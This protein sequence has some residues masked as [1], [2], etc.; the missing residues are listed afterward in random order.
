MSDKVDFGPRVGCDPEFFV[1]MKKG[2]GDEPPRKNTIIP[3]CGLFG[4]TK[5]NPNKLTFK[6]HPE[7]V[8][9]VR[10][11]I[12]ND[13]GDY[14]YQEDN[15]TFEFNIPAQ[16]SYDRFI[17]VVQGF[18]MYLQEQVLAPKRMAFASINSYNFKPP[19]LEHPFAQTIGCTPDHDA[20]AVGSPIRKA[21]DIKGLGT[22]R[23]GGGHIHVQYNTNNIPRHVFARFMDLFI[24]LPTL[25]LDK[26]GA[27]RKFYGKA[28]IFRPKSYGIEYRTPSNFWAYPENKSKEYKQ[29]FVSP[30]NIVSYNTFTLANTANNESEL[31][32]E[33]YTKIPWQDVQSA[34][35]GEDHKLADDIIRYVFNPERLDKPVYTINQKMIGGTIN[36]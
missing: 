31:L 19:Q 13:V 24:A 8:N 34:I 29:K 20:Y 22:Q 9:Y 3:A 5:E 28:G 4:G 35:N 2:E 27:R 16:L 10:L 1:I 11:P 26:Q 15:V 7:L 17:S 30:L 25:R 18:V 32:A 14:A 21:F 33:V 36:G 6:S 23:F 12:E